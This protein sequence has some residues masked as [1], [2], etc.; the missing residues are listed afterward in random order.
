MSKAHEHLWS[1]CKKLPEDYH[2]W[3]TITDDK[4]VNERGE[5]LWLDCSQGC[6]W[7]LP[8][9]GLLSMDWG[10]CTNPKSHR[11]GLLTF[12]HQGCMK[13]EFKVD[14]EERLNSPEQE[15]TK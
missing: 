8:V 14:W 1:V 10:V 9:E 11:A 12:E 6:V 3:G 2:P 4:R 13:A 15:S 5:E 7:Y